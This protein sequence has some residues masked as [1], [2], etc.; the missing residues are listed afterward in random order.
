MIF[1]PAFT[2]GFPATNN[3]A[4]SGC[5]KWPKSGPTAP[6]HRREHLY[7]SLRSINH[8]QFPY[9]APVY[10]STSRRLCF[11]LWLSYSFL[12]SIERLLVIRPC[13]EASAAR[14]GRPDSPAAATDISPFL[15]TR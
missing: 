12:S 2:G 15:S 1:W 5:R 9:S 10:A 6:P 14:L 8:G 13:P 7:L 3:I 11:S 4:R